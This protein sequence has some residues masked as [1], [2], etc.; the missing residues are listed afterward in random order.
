MLRYV[1][2]PLR[3]TEPAILMNME[4]EFIQFKTNQLGTIAE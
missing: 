4:L 1:S 3:L 2:V